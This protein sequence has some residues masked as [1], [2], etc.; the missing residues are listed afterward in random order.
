MP[1]D[2]L[3]ILRSPIADRATFA[4]RAVFSAARLLMI[5]QI[6]FVTL[7][8]IDNSRVS[9]PRHTGTD[10]TSFYAAGQLAASGTPQLAYNRAAHHNAERGLVGRDVGYN[11]FFY[12]PIFLMLCTALALLPPFVAFGLLEAVPL[13]IGLALARRILT[14][15]YRDI[16][17]CVL[18]FPP[19][20]WA[21]VSGQNAFLTASLMGAGTMYI[22]NRPVVAGICFGALS[23]KPQFAILVVIALLAGSHWRS[24]AAAAATSAM[25]AGVSVALFGLPTWEAFIRVA[26]AAHDSYETGHV[27]VSGLTSVFGIALTLGVSV[28][29]AYVLQLVASFALALAV[30]V[31]WNRPVS[32]AIRGAVLA[33]ATP[34]AVPMTMF[35]DLLL[36]GLGLIWLVRAKA[37]GDAFSWQ[38]GVVIACYPLSL[39]CGPSWHVFSAPVTA[40][41][42]VTLALITLFRKLG[43]AGAFVPAASKCQGF[44]GVRAARR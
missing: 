32:L 27:F 15:R 2:Q 39:L 13:V 3:I 28:G 1:D 5:G 36:S 42:V 25:L 16:F 22:G 10:F 29:G 11:F 31:A 43:P 33:A 7:A 38:S 18:A 40:L 21:A 6:C 26:L 14:R 19:V 17:P 44:I 12:P 9:P 8:L 34:V 20:F 35:Y 4:R 23:Y 30:F 24:L 37:D 41:T